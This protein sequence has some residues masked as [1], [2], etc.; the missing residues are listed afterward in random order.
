MRVYNIKYSSIPE[1]AEFL[2]T[3][4]EKNYKSVLVQIFSGIKDKDVLRDIIF[5]IKRE[6][7]FSHI[8]GTSTAGEILDGKVLEDSIV[9]SLSFFYNTSLSSYMIKDTSSY[10]MGEKIAKNIVKENTK[11]VIL[12]ADGL[13]CNAEEILRGFNDNISTELVLSGG[14]AGDYDRF[15]ST[16][17][18]FNEEIVSNAAVGVAFHNR[19]LIVVDK[20]NLSWEPLGVFLKVTKAD[21]N[22]VYEI[23]G[24]PI[25][26]VYKEY[27]GEDIV[28][29]MPASAIEFPLILKKGNLEVARSIVSVGKDYIVFGGEIPEGSEV[30]FG[31]ANIS[32][33]DKDKTDLF[34]KLKM[35]SL[36]AIF[37]FS[38]IARKTFLGKGIEDEFRGLALI[39]PVSGFFTYGEIYTNN[40]KFEL[41][42]ITTTILG[43]SESKFLEKK[44]L[45][46]K[47]NTS[48]SLSTSALIHLVNKI[49]RELK[50]ES[51][52]KKEVI[53]VLNQYLKAIDT[54]YIIS[55]TDPKGIITD[56]ND[57]FV[58]ISGYSRE[59]LIGKPHNIVRHPDMPK[60][61]FADLWRTIKA[62]KIWRGLIKNRRKDGSSYYV[63]STI[64]PL[65]DKN[66]EITGYVGIRVDVTQIKLQ[67][68]KLKAI[69]DFQD[70]IVVLSKRDEN[71]K[72]KIEF[73]NKKFFE[74]FGFENMDDF[75]KDHKCICDLFVKKEGYFYPERRDDYYLID[76]LLK[77]DKPQLV[78]MRDKNGCEKI[79]SVKAKEITLENDSFIISTF[80]DVTELEKA[81]VR[82]KVAE[83]TKSIFLATMSHELR[84]PLNA[85]IGFS[86]VLINKIDSMPKEMI[87]NYIEKIYIAGKHLLNLVN[88]ILDFTKLESNQTIEKEKVNLKD[89]VKEAVN[90]IEVNAREKGIEIVTELEDIDAF[91]NK[92]YLQQAVLNILS[93]AIKFTPEGK[94]IYVS[95]KKEEN[96][97]VIEICDEGMGIKKEDLDKIFK[98][99]F[100]IKEHQ[101]YN[102]KG[103][104]LGLA[105]TKKIIE[106]HRG[107]IEV[108]SEEGKGSCFR[109]YIP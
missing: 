27:L 30:R 15:E 71:K 89:I 26:E 55:T 50:K 10:S 42:N 20:F 85:V 53:A 103:T 70:S 16:F 9:I 49:V 39:A 106:L 77:L 66:G 38:C 97:S 87:K 52:E 83:E 33:F 94:K 61:V 36:E 13:K 47:Y 45:E 57:N 48:F 22:K 2:D 11:A 3:I 14:L 63:D 51:E 44:N 105:I 98:P 24:K 79:F 62:K 75:L 88:N 82:A 46:Y 109:L 80:N 99:F 96:F 4:E 102:V 54:S 7:P 101:F 19:D 12:Y 43:L 17:V 31:V 93:N 37:V 64:F 90:I 67:Q 21:K 84:T 58:K 76:V 5:T 40:R 74:I 100:Q 65:L 29:N 69:L 72:L 25:L 8:I 107:K 59:E 23:N 78:V 28:K 68:E 108:K 6:Y 18:I 92:Q 73:I 32:L 81:R 35:Y 91:V 34:D 95:L 60:E 1:L 104:G 56:V 41:L 86:Q